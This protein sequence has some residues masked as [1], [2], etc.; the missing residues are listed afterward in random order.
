MADDTQARPFSGYQEWSQFLNKYYEIDDQIDTLWKEGKKEEVKKIRN[1][2]DELREEYIRRLPVLP[3]SRCPFC[4]SLF[5]FLFD[6]WGLEGFWWNN[7]GGGISHW[8]YSPKPC[9][10]FILLLGALNLN[11][12][13]PKGGK[14]EC[15]PGPEIPYV[16]ARILNAHRSRVAVISSIPIHNG[17]TAYPI[18]YFTREWS[19]SVGSITAHWMYE[20]INIG[21][22]WT[23]K[24]EDVFDYELLPWVQKGK[25]K[26][27]EP[28]DE[29]CTISNNPKFPYA[30][31]P[32][33]R[34]EL[35][36]REDKLRT[37]YIDEPIQMD[38][39]WSYLK[40]K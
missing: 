9:K 32:G 6:P 39:I 5:K 14:G 26:W 30:N 24:P 18:A 28:N 40:K 17:Y 1:I 35:I 11:G 23:D 36:I 29:T 10:H 15:R 21:A 38:E 25:I 22:Y 33:R 34:K 13:P 2:L 27:I 19:V 37:V 31:L 8:D 7:W 4:G 20:T 16:I 12:L 3:L